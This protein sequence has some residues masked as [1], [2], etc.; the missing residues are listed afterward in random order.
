MHCLQSRGGVVEM[1][2][3]GLQAGLAGKGAELETQGFEFF[4]TRGISQEQ[5]IFHF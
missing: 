2:F 3:A 5:L 1:A 4:K